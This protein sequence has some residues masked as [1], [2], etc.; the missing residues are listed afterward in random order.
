MGIKSLLKGVVKKE[1]ANA[2]I[3]KALPIINK[4]PTSKKAKIAGVL[5]AVAG[6][7]TAISQYLS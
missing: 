5:A 6:L 7:L 1:A 2:V 4:A 3:G